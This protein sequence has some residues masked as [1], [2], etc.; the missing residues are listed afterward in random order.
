MGWE[1]EGEEWKQ[2]PRPVQRSGTPVMVPPGCDLFDDNCMLIPLD[3]LPPDLGAWHRSIVD[4]RLKKG[5]PPAPYKRIL[6]IGDIQLVGAFPIQSRA[7]KGRIP[8][9]FDLTRL[10]GS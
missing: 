6:T 4:F 3:C 7:H 10:R 1:E 5:E 9:S 8:V 2:K